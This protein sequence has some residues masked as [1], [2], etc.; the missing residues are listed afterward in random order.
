MLTDATGALC[1]KICLITGLGFKVGAMGG[2]IIHFS[3]V[4]VV[5][6]FSD[7]YSGTTVEGGGSKGP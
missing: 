4:V 5:V 6:E 1:F 2:G 3:V 7:L